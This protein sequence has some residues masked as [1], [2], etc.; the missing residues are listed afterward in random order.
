ML[1]KLILSITLFAFI[2]SFSQNVVKGKMTPQ[3]KYTWVILY[4]LRG[5]SQQY[6]GNG[7]IKDSEFTLTFPKGSKAGMYRILY[8]NT[9][10]KYID[11]LYNNEDIEFEFHPEYPNELVKF[12]S[13]DENILFQKYIEDISVINTSM[14]SIQVAYIANSEKTKS[15][16]SQKAYTKKLNKA[17]K[18]QNDFELKADKK[19]AYNFIRANKRYF[20]KTL[21]K[22]NKSLMKSLSSHYFDFIDF[23]NTHLKQSS[24][25]IDRIL[26]YVFVLNISKDP[27]EL[28]KLREQSI[29][30]VLSKIT[31]IDLKKD[32]IESIMYTFA[33]KEDVKMIKSIVKNH[34]NKLPV[35]L[36]DYEF[37]NAVL[38]MVKTTVGVQAPNI[39]WQDKKEGS[40]NLYNLKDKDYY[41]VVF[42]ST[43]CPHCL[44]E[45]PKLQ[46]LVKEKT[47]VQVIA[48]GLETNESKYNWIDETY[49]YE[50]FIHI[51][52]ENKYK[53]QYVKD[54]GVSSTPNF[55]LLNADK[56]IIAKPYDVKKLKEY[57]I[58]K[59]I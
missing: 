23:N 21:L 47:N 1:K 17:T 34:F 40:K 45:L 18:I 3:G 36:Q 30:T 31:N 13:S 11:V 49:F 42:W 25:L 2:T 5:V 28:I 22:D 55:F 20:P 33:Q 4:Q 43:T 39:I 12:S 6:I 57:F 58:Q 37:K 35:A 24:L 46:K 16:K 29:T 51:M 19:L 48:I 9:N 27:N 7:T 8:D 59:K 50:D 10:N 15:D 26:S 44:Q 14:D 53:N 54:Y 56:K 41:L 52:G 32:V 38:D